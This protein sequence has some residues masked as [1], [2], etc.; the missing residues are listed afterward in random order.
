[1]AKGSD[2]LFPKVYLEERLSDGSDTT[3]PAADHRALFLGE[4]GAL[5]LKD[6]AA[7]VT[8]VGGSSLT[9]EDEGTPLATAATTL[10]FVGAGVTATGAGAEKTITIPGGGSA[11]GFA[12]YAVIPGM[13]YLNTTS[14]GLANR[15]QMCLMGVGPGP[16]KLRGLRVWVVGP[17]SGTHEWGLFDASASATAA[18]KVAGGTGALGTGGAQVIAATGAP[19]DL[20]PGSY[21]LI[22]KWP[23]ANAATIMY[24]DMTSGGANN[25]NVV[26]GRRFD[27]TYTWDDTP[28]LTAGGWTDDGAVMQFILVGDMDGSGN[29]W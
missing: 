16:M 12:P 1:M 3:T 8:G 10:D 23:A 13:H 25:N 26:F 7:A 19:V 24:T 27:P 11:A 9:V 20:D 17:G 29:Q 6:S 22:W 4:D 28:D 14:F 15:A 21:I 5:H 18:T 2:N